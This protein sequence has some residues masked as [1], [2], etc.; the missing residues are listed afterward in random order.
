VTSDEFSAPELEE[1][2]MGLDEAFDDLPPVPTG[3][4]DLAVAAYGWRRVDAELAELLFDS[5]SDDLVGVRSTGTGTSAERRSFRFGINESVIR[6]HLTAESLIVMI[7]PPLSIA[8]QV[9][10]GFDGQVVEHRTDELGEL[11]IDAPELPVR[12]EFQFPGGRVVTPW[13]IG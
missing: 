4:H 13:I 5:A 12:I 10:C 7:E 3:L 9:A 11:I 6:V 2:L 1:L 8:C